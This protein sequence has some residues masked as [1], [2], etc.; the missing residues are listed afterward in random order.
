MISREKQITGDE[1]EDTT[2]DEVLQREELDFKTDELKLTAEESAAEKPDEKSKVAT[3]DRDYLDRGL[4]NE[5]A[6]DLLS[7][8]SLK[9][10]SEL[11]NR[12]CKSKI[13]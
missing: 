3:F 5:Q 1:T 9:L 10:P 8:L 12:N 6:M 2:D 11:M 13:K 7:F 4:R